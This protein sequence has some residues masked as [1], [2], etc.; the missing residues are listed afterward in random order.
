MKL[1]ELPKKNIYEVPADYF[2]KL[3][4]VMMTRVQ[5]KHRRS[6]SA[7]AFVGQAYWLRNALAGLALVLG[8]F[9]IFL[10]NSNLNTTQPD[11]NPEVL[12]AKVSK[13]EAM[14]YLLNNEQIHATDLA[15]LSQADED[16]SYEFIQAS[17]D[18]IWH[19]IELTDLN[20]ITS[21]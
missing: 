1:D 5:G 19:E 21:N 12:L 8:I 15:Y 6:Q 4:G 9:F 16:I 3:P 20:D 11:Q 17:E 2:E 13:T 18:D 7:W 10:F 14:D